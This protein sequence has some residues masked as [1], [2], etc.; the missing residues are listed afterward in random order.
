[1]LARAL[2]RNRTNGAVE[3]ANS[4]LIR[5]SRLPKLRIVGCCETAV[6]RRVDGIRRMEHSMRL[7]GKVA[8]ITG[9]GTGIGAAIAQRFANEGATVHVTGVHMENTRKVTMD[10]RDAGYDAVGRVLDVTDSRAVARRSRRRS[11]SSEGST[12]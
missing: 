1:M 11:A 7:K 3:S 4:S 9:A 12:S 8:L 5:L 10:L 2:S 6:L